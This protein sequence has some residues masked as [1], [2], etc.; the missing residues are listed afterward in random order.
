[1]PVLTKVS[2]NQECT[3]LPC[4]IIG[5]YVIHVEL[6]EGLGT[7]PVK[8]GQTHCEVALYRK[9]QI[10][11][12]C[13]KYKRFSKI[14]WPHCVVWHDNSFRSSVASLIILVGNMYAL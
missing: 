7:W 6:Q 8:K 5:G 1:M 2:L 10:V 9:L 12:N 13:L 11:S 3:A 14:C 4:D